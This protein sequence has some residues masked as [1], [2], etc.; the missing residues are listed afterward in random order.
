MLWRDGPAVGGWRSRAHR[1]AGGWD[2]VGCGGGLRGRGLTHSP[3]WAGRVAAACVH[4]KCGLLGC[5]RSRGAVNGPSNSTCETSGHCH[6]V[7]CVCERCGLPHRLGGAG[8]VGLSPP[9]AV[10]LWRARAGRLIG[11]L[12]CASRE[13]ATPFPT[14][15]SAPSSSQGFSQSTFPRVDWMTV[16]VARADAM[17]G[18]P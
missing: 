17:P 9:T 16:T 14:V 13:Q 10:G 1:T 8:S 4:H 2:G 6:P 11:M 18:H 15:P 12:A 5:A 3:W 7:G